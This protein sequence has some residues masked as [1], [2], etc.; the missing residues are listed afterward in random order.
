MKSVRFTRRCKYHLPNTTRTPAHQLLLLL[1]R[2]L[3]QLHATARALT[4]DCTAPTTDYCYQIINTASRGELNYYQSQGSISL[5]CSIICSKGALEVHIIVW[6]WNREPVG[7]DSYGTC[8]QSTRWVT[9][10]PPTA[11][12]GILQST[13]IYICTKLN[14]HR[15]NMVLSTV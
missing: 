13:R 1:R 3:P 7:W 9:V 11:W 15:L 12:Q 10:E 2:P 4:A 14:N 5:V 6:Q 8:K